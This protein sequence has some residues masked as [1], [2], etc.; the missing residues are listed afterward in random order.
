M[1]PAQRLRESA[2]ICAH[3]LQHPAWTA[4]RTLVSYLPLPDEV[5]VTPVI[6]AGL[7]RSLTVLVPRVVGPDLCW[8]AIRSLDAA[9]F[10]TGHFGI[11]EP[12]PDCTPACDLHTTPTPR[13]WLVPGVAFDL[14][15]GRLGRGG[16]Y[17]DRALRAAGSPPDTV[18]VAFS[19][20]LV[21][22]VPMAPTDYRL[23]SVVSPAGWHTAV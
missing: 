12:R 8:H 5:D 7:A 20:Q 11:R 16:G 14:H 6:A 4:A 13:L 19:C 17:Y 22:L 10:L 2:E 15:G 18:G 21:E 9:A 1:S 3:I 23:T